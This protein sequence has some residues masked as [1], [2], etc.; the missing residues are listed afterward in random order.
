MSWL[1]SV[2]L[3]KDLLPRS[4]E[5]PPGGRD[6]LFEG[7]NLE[8]LPAPWSASSASAFIESGKRSSQLS[9]VYLYDN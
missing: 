4:V 7:G 9:R 3:E 2:C 8:D 1:A 6:G 5:P